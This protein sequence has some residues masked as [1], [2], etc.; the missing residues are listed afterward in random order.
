MAGTISLSNKNTTVAAIGDTCGGPL[1]KEMRVSADGA[2]QDFTFDVTGQSRNNMGWAKK[3]FVFTADDATATVEFESLTAS[4]CGPALDNVSVQVLGFSLD[5]VKTLINSNGITDDGNE[6]FGTIEVSLAAEQSY[7][8]EIKI[9]NTGGS[10]E[11]D[12]GVVFDVIPAEFDLDPAAAAA[13][14][15]AD[16]AAQ[17]DGLDGSVDGDCT[18]Q[19]A[20]PDCDGDVDGIGGPEL[21]SDGQC[22]NGA[23]DGS[24]SACDGIVS[25]NVACMPS[26][27]TS[28]GGGKKGGDGLEP[29]FV[30]IELSSGLGNTEMCT[31]T[32]AVV[33]DENPSSQKG[34]KDTQFEPT[35]CHPFLDKN[36]DVI[37][38]DGGIP[39]VDWI[40]LNDGVKVFEPENGALVSGPTGSIQL[41]PVG[42]DTDG[43]GV[44]DVDDA[45]PLDPGVQ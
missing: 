23:L 4:Q 35:G 40:A 13:E 16:A 45:D 38:D 10:G 7:E 14:D 30:T 34:N 24:T 9:T 42:C 8:F 32:V 37:V 31:I 6:A 44:P 29:E 19:A 3:V 12:G 43:D 25:D 15:A 27:T 22:T 21:A 18:A 20:D 2:T 1:V 5:V 28:G 39:I 26:T 17:E 36:G 33:T 41:R 11:A